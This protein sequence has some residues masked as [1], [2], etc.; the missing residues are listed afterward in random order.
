[1]KGLL[2]KRIKRIPPGVRLF[3]AISPL[4][5]MY[6]ILNYLPLYGWIYAFF[7][8]KATRSLSEMEF[9]G[10]RNFTNLFSNPIISRQTIR[11]LRNTLI[12][13]GIGIATSFLPM[14]FAIALNELRFPR[15]KKVVQTL[16]TIPNF[17]S[18]VIVYSIALGMF[19][20]ESG[21]VNNI[22]K[23]LGIITESIS[24][25]SSDKH[26]Y[27][28][29][30][31]WGTWKGIGWSA[32]IYLAGISGIDQEL[33]DAA[34]IDGA[35]RFQRIWYVTI[36]CLMPTFITLMILSIGNLLN[37][38]MSYQLV[39]GNSFNLKYLENIDY[40][41]F[42]LGLTGGKMSQAIAIGITKSLV[43][44]VLLF[45]SNWVSGKVRE[46]KIF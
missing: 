44:L 41:V 4:L 35:G 45:F 38:G 14:F 11:A 43:A 26:V 3:L 23:S 8:Y 7:D 29:N 10:L 9:V 20:M 32:V 25:L 24:F 1:M 16:T 37:T 15:L 6:V 39:F 13:S 27:L 30:F 19:S 33:M 28:T 40:L 5:L 18:W 31:L 17:V 2:I 46:E 12:M 42:S 22:L 34:A 36:P 21:V